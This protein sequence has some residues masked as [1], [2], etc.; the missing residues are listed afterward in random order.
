MT[1]PIAHKPLQYIPIRRHSL[2][3]GSSACT[4]RVVSISRLS[5]STLTRYKLRVEGDS[6]GIEATVFEWRERTW[7]L[8]ECVVCTHLCI[9]RM[10]K[11]AAR[12]ISGVTPFPAVYP[13]LLITS[14]LH[15]CRTSKSCSVGKIIIRLISCCIVSHLKG[16]TNVCV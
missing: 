4:I 5:P 3:S 13:K 10:T 11:G 1:I 6:L 15:M 12:L 9:V 16:H 2:G 8:S 14:F 7:L